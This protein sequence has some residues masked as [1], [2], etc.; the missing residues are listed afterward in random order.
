M[1][2]PLV[3]IGWVLVAPFTGGALI[4]RSTTA[5]QLITR[6]YVACMAAGWLGLGLLFATG[7]QLLEGTQGA[8]AAVTGGT[9]SGLAFWIR[10]DGDDGSGEESHEDPDPGPSDAIDWEAFMRDLDAYTARRPAPLALAASK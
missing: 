10:R 9:L 7:V 5:R 6:F 2:L 8:V 1:A 3:L 4:A